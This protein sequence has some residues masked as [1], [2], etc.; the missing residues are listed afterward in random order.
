VATADEWSQRVIDGARDVAA[1]AERARS[2]GSPRD[3]VGRLLI[4]MGRAAGHTDQMAGQGRTAE[5][6]RAHFRREMQQI[7][8]LSLQLLQESWRREQ[9]PRRTND[10]VAGEI[11]R[12]RVLGAKALERQG[13]SP[14]AGHAAA[15]LG[16]AIAA[17]GRAIPT[18]PLDD[19]HLPE[20]EEVLES[21]LAHSL[22]AVARGP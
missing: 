9:R 12:R 13:Q 21:V 14:P 20:L 2:A 6:A 8:A 4:L 11:A 19:A 3:Y 10:E 22:A 7:G 17:I 18:V 16:A 5:K 15:G 1:A